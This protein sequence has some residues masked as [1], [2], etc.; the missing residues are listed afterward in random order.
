MDALSG[1]WDV[2]SVGRDAKMTANT[3][4][5]VRIPQK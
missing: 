5:N 4:G 3:L 2:S 1:D